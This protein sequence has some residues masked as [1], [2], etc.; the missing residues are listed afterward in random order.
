MLRELRGSPVLSAS[1]LEEIPMTPD[2]DA[3]TEQPRPRGKKA[4]IGGTTG[5][6]RAIAV[7]LASNGVDVFI[8]GRHPEH[9]G[10]ALQRIREVGQG[11]ALAV[12]LGD[13]DNVTLPS[14]SISC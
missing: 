7:P 6:G 9:L 12:Y 11:G 3:H 2:V 8:W 13:A 5:I 1:T 4:L 10:D 14:A